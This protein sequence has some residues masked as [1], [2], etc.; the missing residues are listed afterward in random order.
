MNNDPA[1][2]RRRLE[3]SINTLSRWLNEDWAG[4]VDR[5]ALAQVL[6]Y[7]KYSLDQTPLTERKD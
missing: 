5:Y 7:V 3:V 2:T 4:P 6:A 1:E